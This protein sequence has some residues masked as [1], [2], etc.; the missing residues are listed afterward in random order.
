MNAKTVLLCVCF[1]FFGLCANAYERAQQI[2]GGIVYSSG[3]DAVFLKL[4]TKEKFN[5]T[6]D[7][8]EAVKPPLAVSENGKWLGWFQDFRFHA[9]ELPIG[10]SRIIRAEVM[11]SKGDVNSR[12]GE[13]RTV[14]GKEDIVWQ[15]EIR[16]FSL[17]PDGARF[18]FESLHAAPSWMLLDQGNPKSVARAVAAGIDPLKNDMVFGTL[19]LYVKKVDSFNGIFYLS[20]TD[21]RYSP[22]STSPFTPAFGNVVEWPPSVLFKATPQDLGFNLDPRTI[23]KPLGHGLLGTGTN[24]G[25]VKND[26]RVY[27]SVTV[28]KNA[29]LL[30]FQKLR[31]W[32]SGQ[33]KAAFIYQ[34]GSQWGPIEIQTLDEKRQ[35]E[36]DYHSPD[37]IKS[38]AKDS[39]PENYQGKARELEI[40][41]MFP[42]VEALAWKP[43]GSLSVFSQ[44][45]VFL[46]DYRQ[47]QSAFDRSHMEMVKDEHDRKRVNP[48]SANNVLQPQ[49]ELVAKGIKGTCFNWVSDYSFIF[50]GTDN[51]VYLWNQGSV[52]KIADS[53]GEFSYCSLSPLESIKDP[54]I[55]ADNRSHRVANNSSA[56]TGEGK[57]REAYPGFS[58]GTIQTVWAPHTKS[59]VYIYIKPLGERK[60][61]LQFALVEDE[62]NLDNI[63]DPSRYEYLSIQERKETVTDKK[64]ALSAKSTKPSLKNVS[65]HQETITSNENVR[66]TLDRIII[67][68]SGNTY[69]GIKPVSLET[70]KA[71]WQMAYKWKYWPKVTAPEGVYAV[72]VEKKEPWVTAT[73]PISKEFFI[74]DTKFSWEKIPEGYSVSGEPKAQFR[75][76][77]TI[78]DA[79]RNGYIGKASDWVN[80]SV[81]DPSKYNFKDLRYNGKVSDTYAFGF[82]QD[83]ILII[84]IGDKYVAIKPVEERKGWIQYKWK[85]WP[86][87]LPMEEALVKT[88]LR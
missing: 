16:N 70:E 65:V 21:N 1:L 67:L 86:E 68:K 28:K 5:L 72:R 47:I 12:K 15:R 58:V 4:S 77:V 51:N 17:S 8:S 19:P 61:P 42:S 10:S 88:A 14:I 26:I 55:F 84:K 49:L 83:F 25:E 60:T 87:T 81:L 27:S 82:L 20:I 44:G 73:S 71:P 74:N 2:P 52:E 56:I 54:S 64:G 50:L 80:T 69:V 11:G 37:R 30:T 59:S 9:K 6:S 13:T 43:D 39:V 23:L 48:L 7:L 45:N 57:A 36:K 46:V 41:T 22:P 62:D 78:N 38:F 79:D 63:K 33:K 18:A 66:L 31:A 40:Q 76:R 32:E 24:G 29:S 3:K 53:T 35:Y 85:C 75:L 34:V